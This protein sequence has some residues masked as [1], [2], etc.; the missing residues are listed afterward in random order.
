MTLKSWCHQWSQQAHKYLQP[1][2]NRINN[3]QSP[4]HWKYNREK[5]SF[6]VQNGHQQEVD[7]STPRSGSV[8]IQ[9]EPIFRSSSS[10]PRSDSFSSSFVVNS[11]STLYLISGRRSP[12]RTS[13][14]NFSDGSSAFETT[15]SWGLPSSTSGWCLFVFTVNVGSTPR[16]SPFIPVLGRKFFNC[17]PGFKK[18]ALCSST[19]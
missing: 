3:L 10:S 9:L 12:D 2:L 5:S 13:S 8:R 4:S 11:W 17:D 16:P 15:T 14:V 6:K 18:V 1:K 19:R 7:Q